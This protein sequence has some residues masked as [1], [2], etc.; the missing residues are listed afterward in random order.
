MLEF[1]IE[2][3]DLKPMIETVSMAICRKSPISTLHQIYFH[4]T[5]DQRLRIYGTDLSHFVEIYSDSIC[6]IEC[7]RVGIDVDD[8]K[9]IT[10]MVGSITITETTADGKPVVTIKNQKKCVTLPACVEE[11][12]N[13]P[14]MKNAELFM[15]LDASWLLETISKLACFTTVGETNPLLGALCLNTC[16]KQAEAL[17]GHHVGIRKMPEAVKINQLG[18]AMLSYQS[19]P[20]LKKL[21]D[22]NQDMEV[23]LLK[24]K[25]YIKITGRDFVYVIR[26]IEGEYFD[27][28]KMMMD[29][30]S[31]S[32]YYFTT[33]K[34]ALIKVIQ[35]GSS[36]AK[37]NKTSLIFHKL[38]GR[39]FSHFDSGRYEILDEIDVDKMELPEHF[40]F[41]FTPCKVL[42]I[43]KVLDTETMTLH[44][45]NEKS[46]AYI[47]GNEYSF[48]ICAAHITP[49]NKEAVRKCIHAEHP[50]ICS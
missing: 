27:V 16:S 39:L 45:E 49:D 15:T 28:G 11:G 10:K 31:R 17:D 8:L 13:L 5:E 20:I 2:S 21:L 42:D 48:L 19:F 1:T 23:S 7:G 26:R 32:S 29:N 46:C 33:S 41:G 35:Y 34:E 43:L 40:F 44:I 50:D 47:Q 3:K 30:S 12:I 38:G 25:K 18:T 4:T 22:K 36:L 24:E 37:K 9:I 14:E 6:G